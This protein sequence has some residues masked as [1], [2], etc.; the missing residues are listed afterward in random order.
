M[1]SKV[2][3]FV[4]SLEAKNWTRARAALKALRDDPSITKI[5]RL[6]FAILLAQT[7]PGNYTWQIMQLRAKKFCLQ[8]FPY[9]L[10]AMGIAFFFFGSKWI[11]TDDT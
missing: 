2:A 5:D 10:I 3:D 9:S 6:S 11:L 7:T 1:S 8:V 4:A